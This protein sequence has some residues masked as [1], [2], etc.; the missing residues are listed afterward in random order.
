MHECVNM[1]GRHIVAKIQTENKY[2][3]KQF[4]EYSNTL[5]CL[6]TLFS[7]QN[8]FNTQNVFG[9]QKLFFNFQKLSTV[10]KNFHDI[11]KLDSGIQTLLAT[12]QNSN[13]IEISLV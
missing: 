2:V 7:V 6:E 13:A 1:Y 12:F 5:Q 9:V 3:F 11:Q 8:L 10:F 4:I